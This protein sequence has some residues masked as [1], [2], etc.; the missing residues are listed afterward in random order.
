MRV[1]RT[2]PFLRFCRRHV[3]SDYSLCEVVQRVFDAGADADLGGGVFKQ[4]TARP[5][6][7]KS[8]GFR[9]VLLFRKRER[10]VFVHGFAKNEKSNITHGE[11][12][13]ARDLAEL[14]LNYSE[15]QIDQACKNGTLMELICG[16]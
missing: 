9:L 11:I 16:H 8:G 1:F 10:L 3:I 15:E 2:K 4:R 14:L 12:I 7:G 6:S 5:G 13:A